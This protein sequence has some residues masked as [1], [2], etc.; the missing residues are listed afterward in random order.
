MPG[1]LVVRVLEKQRELLN[2]DFEGPV[3]LGRQ[4]DEREELHAPQWQ[5]VREGP[6]KGQFWRVAVA[7][8]KQ[9]TVSRYHAYIEALDGGRVRLTNRSAKVPLRLQPADAELPAGSQCELNLP[10]DFD[11]STYRVQVRLPE[12]DPNLRVLE[13]V[14]GVP[15]SR[16]GG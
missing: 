7:P 10:A 3:E 14:V 11:L 12:R 16:D 15:G 5:S 9:D 6:R 13:T 4:S 2:R 8:L 1:K